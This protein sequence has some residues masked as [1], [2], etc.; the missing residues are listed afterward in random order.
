MYVCTRTHTH[1]LPA[2]FQVPS[3]TM[4]V[5]APPSL[6][7]SLPPSSSATKSSISSM[8]FAPGPGYR[9]SVVVSFRARTSSAC[10][11]FDSA[12]AKKTKKI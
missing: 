12:P 9:M 10:G 11:A 2:C 6:P 5:R 8:F 3:T 7:P 4:S 1:T